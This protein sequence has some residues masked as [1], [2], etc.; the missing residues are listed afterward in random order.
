MTKSRIASLNWLRVFE[1][2]AQAGSFARAADVLGMSPPGVSQQI[3]ALEGHLGKPLFTRLP[4]SV[5][6]TE[7]GEA[8]LPSVQ[9]ALLSVEGA[10]AGLFGT[11]YE[12]PLYVQ[13]ALLFAL[14]WLN[15]RLSKFTEKNSKIRLRLS[16]AEDFASGSDLQIFFGTAPPPNM[17]GDR[18]FGERLYPVASPQVAEKIVRAGD[19]AGYRLIEV[20]MHRSNWLRWL[21]SAG[22]LNIDHIAFDFTDSTVMSFSRAAAGKCVALARAPAS[23]ALSNT[24]G[25]VPCLGGLA[26]AGDQFYWLIYPVRDG[27][28]PP[29]R[30]FRDWIL[31]EVARQQ[32][33]DE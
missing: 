11:K 28:R 15:P 29:A 22:I 1:A 24:Y 20:A 31:T 12:E 9:Q 32:S 16:S 5:A 19:L 27:L 6:L 13:V 10:A 17:Q 7:A 18:L 21:A 25:L 26:I 4:H 30:K 2:A 14:G 23:D 8:F 3:K 33:Q